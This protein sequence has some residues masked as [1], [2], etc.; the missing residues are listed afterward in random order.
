MVIGLL[1]VTAIPTVI[2]VGQAVSAQKKQ[3]A[4][5]REQEKVNLMAMFEGEEGFYEAGYC[6]LIGGKVSKVALC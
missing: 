2:G 6:V 4:A 3:N 5:S 1:A